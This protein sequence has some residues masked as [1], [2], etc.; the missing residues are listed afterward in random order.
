MET[1][2]GHDRKTL[3][4]L[5]EFLGQVFFMY[6]VL[7][8]VGSDSLYKGIV[9]PLA[10]FA[11]VNIFGGISGGHF[12]PAVTLGVY[13]REAKWEKNFIMLITIIASQISGAIIGMLLASVVLRI[14]QDGDYVILPANIPLQ[15][16]STITKAAI[17]DGS[18][19]L[20][21]TV[22]TFYM[23]TI[24]TF[25]FVLFILHVTGSKTKAV[26]LG[27]WGVPGICL[28]L[29]AL[30]SVDYFNGASFNPA[31]AIGSTVFQ[32]WNYPNN[33]QGVLTY[34]L[35]LY[36]FGAATG[37]ILAGAYYSLHAS[38]FEENDNE[39]SQSEST[40]MSY[41]KRVHN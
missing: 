19:V 9:G 31:L 2:Q 21:E 39:D 27:V 10:L 24:C 41:Q 30:C 14:E 23:E 15:L 32:A 18:L 20:G 5:N 29:W 25:V 3:V 11:I 33:P 37:G 8:S 36:V 1:P 7:V 22:T 26:D 16:P 28:V 6:A 38:F 17:D 40:N 13:V 12:N 34:Y 4:C 35:P